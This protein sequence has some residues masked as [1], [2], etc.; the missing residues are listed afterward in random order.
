MAHAMSAAIKIELS[1]EPASVIVHRF[2]NFGEDVYRALREKCLIR[3]EEID[4]ST[5]SFTLRDIRRRDLGEVTQAIKREL[6]RHHFDA[7]A[8]LTR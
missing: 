6:Q 3:I 4:A 1:D 8:T 5:T 2:R 7:S